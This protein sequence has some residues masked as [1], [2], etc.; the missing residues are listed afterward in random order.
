MERVGLTRRVFAPAVAL[1]NRLG[2]RRKFALISLLFALPLALFLFFM[3][4]ESHTWIAFAEKE[5]QGLEYHGQLRTLFDALED[6]RGSA[7]AVASGDAALTPQL[8]QVQLEIGVAITAVDRVDRE[9]GGVL[10]T[11]EKWQA[12]RTRW[13]GLK[14]EVL[15]RSPREGF[16]AQTALIADLL[17][18]VTHV[19]D[20]SN[21]IIDPQ[22]DSYYLM[23]TLITRLL[24]VVEDLGHA[25]ALGA[26]IATRR[27]A[28]VEERLQ[29]PALVGETRAAVAA[30]HRGLHVAFEVNPALRPR[31]Q[32][33]LEESVAATNQFLGITEARLLGAGPIEIAPE[34][35]L[36]AGARTI[37]AAF[38]L[39]DQTAPALD[40]L[41]R[42]RID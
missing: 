40:E 21:L 17:A 32:G 34:E 1:M 39:Y 4:S 6:Y 37:D 24:R 8:G 41:L 42:V 38:R 9:L 18:L 10:R 36:E 11:R 5:R 3:I 35:Y 22:L 19:G 7:M 20:T 14:D 33:P 13:L 25:R 27:E 12:L 2:Y 29:L 31:L 16:E 23:D 28:T 15:R 26:G 30:M